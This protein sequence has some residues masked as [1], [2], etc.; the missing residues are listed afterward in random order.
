MIIRYRKMEEGAKTP[1]KKFDVDAGFDLTAIWKE[2]TDKY[3]EY[4]TGIAFEIPVGFVGLLFPRSSITKGDLILKNSVGVVDASY[5]GEIKFRYAK[6]HH[7]L[8]VEKVYDRNSFNFVNTKE[9]TSLPEDWINVNHTS[10]R[11]P[12]Y[13]E[14]GDRC[15]QIV[16]MELPKV[17]L[18]QAAE[19]TDTERG[20]KGYGSS[21]NK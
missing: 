1:Y 19:L 7:D 8:F 12:D 16:F 4:G 18:L 13:Y 14:I 21:G 15:G 6:Y 9:D 11:K 5:R 17:D 3:I 10:F 2:E 20:T